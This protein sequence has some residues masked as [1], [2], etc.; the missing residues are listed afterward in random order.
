MTNS[1]IDKLVRDRFIKDSTYIFS[2]DEFS[3]RMFIQELADNQDIQF[4]EFFKRFSNNGNITKLQSKIFA[5]HHGFAKLKGVECGALSFVAIMK[6]LNE[7][8]KDG[9]TYSINDIVIQY[10][11]ALKVLSDTVKVLAKKKEKILSPDQTKYVKIMAQRPYNP[12]V[13]D[14]DSVAK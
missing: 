3:A 5:L 14:V 9:V 13:D 10:N 12:I 4:V 11:M 7:H 8:S 1:Y 6:L 2:D